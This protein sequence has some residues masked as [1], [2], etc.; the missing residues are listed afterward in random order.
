MVEEGQYEKKSGE[1]GAETIPETL[2]VTLLIFRPDV[3]FRSDSSLNNLISPDSAISFSFVLG[4]VI[5]INNYWANHNGVQV[6]HRS[7]AAT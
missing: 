5:I 4:F 1:G 7:H 2:P 3:T 6:S